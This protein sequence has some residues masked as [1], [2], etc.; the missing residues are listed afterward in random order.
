MIDAF[1]HTKGL[2]VDPR[3]YPKNGFMALEYWLTDTTRTYMLASLPYC[4]L[5][6][7]FCKYLMRS[8]DISRRKE[9]Y[10][11]DVVVLVGTG[12]QSYAETCVMLLQSIPEVE[13]I[14]PPSAG[15]QRERARLPLT[16][17]I[18]VPFSSIGVFY[19]DG[20]RTQRVGHHVDEVV[21][22]TVEGIK[23]GRDEV[24]ERAIEIIENSFK[25]R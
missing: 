16:E 21:E 4:K 11:G 2:V 23:A 6:G 3:S 18:T 12:T 24:L 22:P 13:V 7:I 17:N 15:G 5:P 1:G 14:G 8:E 20:G 10:R 25:S 9:C 19:P